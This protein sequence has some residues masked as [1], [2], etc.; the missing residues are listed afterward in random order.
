MW[1]EKLIHS[2]GKQILIGTALDCSDKV[3]VANKVWV[4]NLEAMSYPCENV[5]LSST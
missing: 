4:G 1:I 3:W 2:S 5:I